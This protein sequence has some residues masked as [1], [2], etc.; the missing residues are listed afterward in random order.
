MPIDIEAESICTL[1][2]LARRYDVHVSTINRWRLRGIKGVR[3]ETA[4]IGGKSVTSLEA[5]DRFNEA[6]TAAADGAPAP[7]PE[8]DAA[9]ERRLERVE[10]ELAAAGI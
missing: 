9:R 3:L 8:T 5:G 2:E 7:R 1:P 4:R 10:R 6:V